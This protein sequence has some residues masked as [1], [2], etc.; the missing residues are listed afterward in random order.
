MLA[1]VSNAVKILKNIT[2]I[3]G[4]WG[5][6]VLTLWF[7]LFSTSSVRSADLRAVRTKEAV[8][9]LVVDSG[10]GGLSVVADIAHRAESQFCYREIR[11]VFANAMPRA[12]YGYNQMSSTEEK[13]KVF[14]AALSALDT[15]VHP[16][17]ILLA[18]N[19]LSIVY[20][21][22]E[23]S[24]T[25]TL[26]VLGIVELGA[27]ILAAHLA[28]DTNSRAILFGTETTI[29]DDA[30][31]R[32]LIALGCSKTRIT[33]QA[34]PDL[35]GEIQVNSASDVVQ[36]M[37]DLYA[38]EAQATMLKNGGT[39]YVGLCC[40]HYGY[41]AEQFKKSMER[42]TGGRVVIVDPNS[43][44]AD[45]LFEPGCLKRYSFTNITQR[46]VSRVAFS[47]DEIVSIAR[48]IESVS[49][50]TAEALRTYEYSS[51]LFPIPSRR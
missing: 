19:T 14:S 44:M 33:T 18:C 24:K 34:C 38:S 13:A 35:A 42:V 4:E 11:L 48:L 7:T 36:T 26:P 47:K 17:V 27:R 5:M 15:S 29:E 40:T 8:T 25:T 37:I 32:M 41:A 51:S 1:W 3:G 49:R 9:V 50:S 23:F 16:D 39:T 12:D 21:A 28:A 30:H 43:G 45:S 10:L 22:T 2:G 46:V 6:I 20:P 31:R